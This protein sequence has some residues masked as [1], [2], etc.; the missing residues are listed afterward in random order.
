MKVS[1]IEP[2]V[3]AR[4]PILKFDLVESGLSVDICINLDSGL[5]TGQLMVDYLKDYPPLQPLLLVLK[6]FLVSYP[7]S[8]TAPPQTYS[9]MFSYHIH[10]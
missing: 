4:V 9:I 5:R 2:V 8:S 10:I 6:V 1:Y 7:P 3:N